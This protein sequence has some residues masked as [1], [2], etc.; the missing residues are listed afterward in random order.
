MRYKKGTGRTTKCFPFLFCC[1][2]I[3]DPG[4]IKIR[5]RDKYPGSAT[6][7]SNMKIFLFP[8]L[9]FVNIKNPHF[10][11]T[12]ESEFRIPGSVTFWYGGSSDPYL[13]LT[14]PALFVSDLQD[15]NKNKFFLRFFML[16]GTFKSFFKDQGFSSYFCLLNVDGTDYGS[17][18]LQ[19][20]PG[21]VRKQ[22]AQSM[23]CYQW[24]L[25]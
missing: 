12:I 21:Y 6:L 13:W 9:Y 2:W 5:I 10:E 7:G 20:M 8:V 17:G 22:E 3:W 14:D 4:W 24:K 23:N 25:N 16:E 19:R 15:T 1:C 11:L 18:T